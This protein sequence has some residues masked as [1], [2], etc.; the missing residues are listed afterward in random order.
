MKK[1]IYIFFI[2]II[3]SGCTIAALEVYSGVFDRVETGRLIDFSGYPRE[4]FW[5]YSGRNKLEG[6]IYGKENDKGLVVI[7]HGIH[8]NADDN[9]LMIKYL[10]DN[11]WR[12][13]AFNNTGVSGSEGYSMLGLSQGLLDLKAALNYIENTGEL[14]GLPIMLLGFSWG[15]YTVCAVLNF[16]YPIKAVVSLS[17]FNS[18]QDVIE[19]QAIDAVG[20]IYYLLSPQTLALER[21]LFGETAKLT[22]VD[23]INK[24][25]IPVLIAISSDDDVI[26]PCTISIYA[27]KRK[28]FNPRAEYL[29]LEG[30]D[31][32]GH[33]LRNY[34]KEGLYIKINEFLEKSR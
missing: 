11:G 1:C 33:R 32:G 29:L 26:P 20:N 6:F 15:G 23:G 21:Q 27:H 7:T 22:A 12:V 28:I 30:E 16:N 2:C 4:E 19:K 18:I 9:H 13:L 25:R 24:T 17:G 8:T 5:F 31:A 34:T 3:L 10:A 14:N